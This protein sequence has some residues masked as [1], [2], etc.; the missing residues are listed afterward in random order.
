MRCENQIL[1]LVTVGG[2]EAQALAMLVN[3]QSAEAT[4]TELKRRAANGI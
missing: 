2:D 3:A 1:N 4:D